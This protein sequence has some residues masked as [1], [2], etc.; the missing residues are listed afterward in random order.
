MISTN[1]NFDKNGKQQGF[2]QLAHS[3]NNAAWANLLIPVTV[4]KNGS[5]PT[6]LVL[7]G[8]HGDEYQGQVAVMNLARQLRP[9]MVSGRIVMIP[10]L[11]FPAA[12]A[13]TRLSPWDGK[14]LNREFPGDPEGTVTEQIADYLTR[15]LFP[16]SDVVID[17]HS[18]GRT[19]AFVPCTCMEV[20]AD[21]VLRKKMLEGTLAWNTDFLMLYLTNIAGTGLLPVEAARQGKIV[22]TTEM[23]GTEM[24]P[25]SVHRLTQG[26]LRNVLTHFGAL[27]GE[28]HTRESL[29]LAPTI[30]C[31]SLSQRDYLISPE[32]GVFE[33]MLDLGTLV[34]TGQTIGRLHFPEVP[35]REPEVITA[36]ANGYLL[37]YRAPCL[38]Q[39]GDCVAV[40]GETADPGTLA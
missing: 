10:M 13:G 17:I 22:I 30:V 31:Q 18:G 11:N 28:E 38:T 27:H 8:T 39:Q 2:L 33:A 12:K 16:M 26:G 25:A 40:I 7:A 9:E 32:S 3:T 35:Q 20:V 21:K 15:V 37:C 1:V 14:N 29:G 23:G 24:I 36:E 5:G 4:I 34:S 19:L 6:V